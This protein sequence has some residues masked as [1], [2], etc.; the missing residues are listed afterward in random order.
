MRKLRMLF[1]L[2]M[3]SVCSWQSAWAQDPVEIDVTLPEPNS[4]ATEILAKPEIDDVKT[5]T[6]LTIVSGTL[7]DQDWATLKSM[8]AL[9]T[10][11][12][13]GAGNDAIPEE[14]FEGS[15]NLTTV[16]L[17]SN[18]KTIG[19]SA[20]SSCDNLVT[21]DV[22]STVE[23]IG[24]SAFS[25]CRKL[26]ECSLAGLTS[27]TAIPDNCFSY[28]EKLKSINIPKKVPFEVIVFISI[29]KYLL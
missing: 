3:V 5:V 4:L 20:F 14:Q 25:Y 27:I 29:R 18:L 15:D 28:C 10:L 22:P 7:G 21:V 26:E 6:K 23:S 1:T 9:L 24:N 12:L 16:Y 8:T 2:L 19:K 13:R 17:P 11:D